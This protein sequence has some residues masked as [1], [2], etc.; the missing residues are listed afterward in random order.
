MLTDGK[1]NSLAGRIGIIGEPAD[2]LI[3]SEVD[4]GD[5]SELIDDFM[6]HCGAARIK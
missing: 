2:W 3:A 1:H 4:R 5:H 6:R